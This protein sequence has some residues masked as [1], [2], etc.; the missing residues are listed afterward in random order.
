M[1]DRLKDLQRQRALAQEQ[2]A[3]L[4]LEIARE[5]GAK[6]PAATLS[7]PAPVRPDPRTPSSSGP[8]PDE[9]IAQFQNQGQSVHSDVR[10]GC[11]IYF[12]AAF[13]LVG[14]GILALYFLR[15]H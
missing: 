12:F 3:W 7:A 13:G 11:L 5:T 6:P 10:R 2:L 4:D 9:I 1:S 15:R 8:S 14:L